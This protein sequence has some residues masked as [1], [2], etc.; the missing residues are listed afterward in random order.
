MEELTER[1]RNLLRAIVEKYIDTAEPVGSETI[2]K[3]F[4]LGVSPATIRNDM[5]RLTK[6]GFLK[7]PH[8]SAGRVPTSVALKLYINQLMNEKELPVKDEVYLKEQLWDYRY[9]FDKLIRQATRALAEQTRALALA[10]TTEGQVYSSGMAN[11][12]DMPEF[13]D[14][15]L[16]KTVLSLLDR[17]EVLQQLFAQAAGEEDIHILL[18]DELDFDYL[19]PC[20]FVFSRFDAGKDHRG[21]IGVIG[22]C[23]LQYPTIIPTVRYLGNLLNQISK[24]W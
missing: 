4:T 23:R 13:Y 1:Q 21:V 18:G 6:L 7:Q 17:V 22:P 2:E 16:T 9:E 8:T 11:I 3:G 14:I 20:G 12:L 24:T 15:D 10:T 5:V 19:E